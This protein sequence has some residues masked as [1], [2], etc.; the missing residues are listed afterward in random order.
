MDSTKTDAR[1]TNLTIQKDFSLI[2]A[3]KQMDLKEAKC[4]LVF[5]GDKFLNILSIGDIQRAIL[6]NQ[7]WDS[8]VLSAMRKDTTL[9]SVRESFD[10]VK[11]K[12]LELRTEIMPVVDDQGKLERVLFWNDV[13]KGEKIHKSKFDLPI[14]IMAG[15]KGTR[16]RP[17]TNVIPKPLIPIGNLT[18][19]EHIMN[20]F[21]ALGSNKFYISINYKAD[22]IK[23]YLR[24]LDNPNYQIEYIQEEKPLGTAGSLFLLKNVI[25]TTFFISNC[26]II[27]DSDYSEVLEYHKTNQNELTIVSALKHI[28]IPYG[29]LETE[30]QGQ[31]L[32]LNEK[33]ELT[34]QI[35]SGLYIL[36]PELLNEI[37]DNS[38]FHITDLIQSIL[39][40]K[41]RIGV[42]PVS[43]GS[44]VDIGQWDEYLSVKD[45]MI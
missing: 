31:L 41:G 39:N 28:K 17:L 3:L 25:N 33:P 24:Q 45:K 2:D 29:T 36:E 6:K 43:Q 22:V 38:F 27:I 40:R 44:W 11:S 7:P 35:N 4:L 34:F 14:I 5:D 18:I 20:K 42:F 21:V 37:P 1:I 23:Y 12:M 19:L 32:S 30:D 9:A 26:D 16:L 13:F 8:S 15:G 10:E